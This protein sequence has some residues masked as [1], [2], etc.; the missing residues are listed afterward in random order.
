MGVN[1]KI[2]MQKV[3]QN[4]GK[5]STGGRNVS[6]D[7]YNAY[8]EL[9]KMG[10]YWW[11]PN[12]NEIVTAMNGL[13]ASFNDMSKT[14]TTEIPT[15]LQTAMTNYA[16]A[17]HTTAPSVAIQSPQ[18][19][20]AL[21]LPSKVE[22]KYDEANVTT[23]KTAIDTQFGNAIRAID[24][25]I[26]TAVNNIKSNWQGEAGVSAEKKIKDISKQVKDNVNEINKQ[27]KSSMEAARQAVSSAES[28]NMYN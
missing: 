6:K 10:N 21:S 14:I 8:N 9:K 24:G 26:T 2:D 16:K 12:Y 3:A 28:A 13:V 11:G 17:F 19:L 18:N 4:A 20:S 22:V 7:F 25:E 1:N 5:L 23:T 15:S 27:F